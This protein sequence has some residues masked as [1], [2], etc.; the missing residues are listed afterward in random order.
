MNKKFLLP[1]IF[2][3][4]IFTS[5]CNG[6]GN[7]QNPSSGD[8]AATT[9]SV[10]TTTAAQVDT[11]VIDSSIMTVAESPFQNFD[12]IASYYDTGYVGSGLNCH[13]LNSC[14]SSTAG[15]SILYSYDQK[16]N[17]IIMA[18]NIAALG[19]KQPDKVNYFTNNS[20][21]A[22]DSDWVVPNK[23]RA[24]LKIAN[25]MVVRGG[26]Q[27]KLLHKGNTYA[28]VLKAEEMKK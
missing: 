21:A 14:N 27:S 9:A 23:I 20:T 17:T 22:F 5:S 26:V 18:V 3:M 15:I 19:K 6:C 13:A 28:I 11:N 12:N 16:T 24:G 1:I 2:L 8:A 25:P 4:G 10:D 7:G